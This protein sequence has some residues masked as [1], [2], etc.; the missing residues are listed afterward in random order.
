MQRKRV[1]CGVL[2][3]LTLALVLVMAACKTTE[4]L[5][6]GP[7]ANFAGNWETKYGVMVITQVGSKVNGYY[8]KAACSKAW[9]PG[10]SW[11][12]PGMTKAAR[13]PWS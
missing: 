3:C 5:R 9:S 7:T 10:G 6:Q 2:L 1:R 12:W 8:P 11:M 13:A 4:E